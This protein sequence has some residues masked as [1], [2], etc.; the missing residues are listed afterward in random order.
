[1]KKGLAAIAKNP[2]YKIRRLQL[3]GYISFIGILIETFFILYLLIK[4]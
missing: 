2:K 4:G 1:M 3:L